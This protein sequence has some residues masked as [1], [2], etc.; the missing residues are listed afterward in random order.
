[1]AISDIDHA[2]VLRAI[3]EFDRLGR[4]AFLQQYGFGP[5]RAYFLSHGG[6]F[7]DSKAIIGAAHGFS[8]GDRRPLAADKF[9][10]GEATV[11]TV[12]HIK[13]GR[14]HCHVV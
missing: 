10:G 9:T 6:R 2:A 13:E 3:D 12:F 5:S 14:E 4:N 1:M 8:G 7:Y 11:A